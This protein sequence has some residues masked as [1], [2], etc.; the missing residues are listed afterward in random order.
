[1]ARKRISGRGGSSLGPVAAAVIAAALAAAPAARAAPQDGF[2]AA[3]ERLAHG[4]ARVNYEVSDPKAEAREAEQLAREARRLAQDHP[5]RAEP[6]A[7]EALLLLCE[8]DAR[9]NLSS[10]GLARQARDLLE[11]ALKLDAAALGPGSVE[12]NL[13]ALYDQ[14]PGAP[15]GFGHA[16]KAERHLR[17]ALAESPDGLDANYFQGQFLAH[18]GDV[19]G[20]RAALERAMA[21]PSRRGWEVADRGRKREAAQLLAKVM[22]GKPSRP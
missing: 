14:V 18:H 6:L 2:P 9:H 21:A 11:A 15:L 17:K 12:A 10:L 16:R 3:V 20:A 4:W 13:G 1:M 7:W 22:A 19:R 8:A 5:G